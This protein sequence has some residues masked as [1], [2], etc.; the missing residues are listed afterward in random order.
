MKAFLSGLWAKTKAACL[1]SITMAWSYIVT[2]TG[3]LFTNIESLATVL[4]DP[5]L[6]QQLQAV[7]G[8]AKLIGKWLLTVGIITT[9]ARLKSLVKSGTPPAPPKA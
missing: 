3:A 6:T 4:G 8:D 2:A 9:L 1:G 7:V 5:G